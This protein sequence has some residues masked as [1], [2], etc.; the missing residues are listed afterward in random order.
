MRNA[1]IEY[2][3]SIADLL[4]LAPPKHFTGLRLKGAGRAPSRISD[5]GVHRRRTKQG[6]R[7]RS[8]L[9]D[10]YEL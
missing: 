10:A 6:T 8:K 3:R 2:G 7:I 4:M 5:S 1:I 9:L